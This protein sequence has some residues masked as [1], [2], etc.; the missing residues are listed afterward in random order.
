[1]TKIGYLSLSFIV[2]DQTY[3]MTTGCGRPDWSFTALPVALFGDAALV[4]SHVTGK[5]SEITVYDENGAR[6]YAFSATYDGP[7]TDIQLDINTKPSFT[8]NEMI[9]L[10]LD[11]KAPLADLCGM[12][13]HHRVRKAPNAAIQ[14]NDVEYLVTAFLPDE[15]FD[16][17]FAVWGSDYV[18]GTNPNALSIYSGTEDEYRD[19]LRDW[20]VVVVNLGGNLYEV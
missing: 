10:L 3:W 16:R 6:Q 14:C 11:Q 12:F 1:M 19:R 9:T 2:G 15:S 4:A 8:W 20:R 7:P 17:V 18:P 13:H 5:M